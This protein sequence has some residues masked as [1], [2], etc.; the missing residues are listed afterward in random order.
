MK[1]W[2]KQPRDPFWSCLP[3]HHIIVPQMSGLPPGFWVT[4]EYLGALMGM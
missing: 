1:I 3:N 2:K 4:F